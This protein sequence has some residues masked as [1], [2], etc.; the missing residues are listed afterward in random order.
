MDTLA[1]GNVGLRQTREALVPVAE[2]HLAHQD[3]DQPFDDR[4]IV[5]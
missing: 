5:S 1:Q 3:L 4:F 2:A